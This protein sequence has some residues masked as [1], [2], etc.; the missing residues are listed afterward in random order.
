L[1]SITGY[2][3]FR[4]TAGGDLD[5]TPV[6]IL[7]SLLGTYDRYLSEEVQLLGGNKR[8]NWVVGRYGGNERGE[9]YSVNTI[10]ADIN[11]AIPT[12]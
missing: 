7:T 12:T 4:R 11:P 9:E 6:N 10:L 5:G 3:H 1:R 2:Q 8:F